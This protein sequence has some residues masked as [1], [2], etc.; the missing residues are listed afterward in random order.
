MEDET[1]ESAVFKP[2]IEEVLETGFDHHEYDSGAECVADE[3]HEP[4]SPK[5][6][7]REAKN[8]LEHVNP[9]QHQDQEKLVEEDDDYSVERVGKVGENRNLSLDPVDDV[10]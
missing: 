5:I 10:L 2:G 7:H 8:Q 1:V 6:V 3:H 9:G 4:G